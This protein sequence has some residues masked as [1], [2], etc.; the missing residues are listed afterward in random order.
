MMDT[1]AVQGAVI[2][3]TGLALGA[4]A[5]GRPARRRTPHQTVPACQCGHPRA[6]HD[7][8]TDQCHQLAYVPRTTS[9]SAHHE[10]C[11]CRQYIGPEPL[12]SVF[13]TGIEL[14][15]DET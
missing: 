3:L 15:R 10:P 11:R 14:P 7:R 1:Q 2:M 6:L 8:A 5:R 4:A 13:T 12:P 9:K